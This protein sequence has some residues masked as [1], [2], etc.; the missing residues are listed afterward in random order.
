MGCG[1]NAGFAR[2]HRD[3]EPESPP[4][5][6]RRRCVR[7]GQGGFDDRAAAIDISRMYR[8]V[9]CLAFAAVTW[10]Q[11]VAFGCDMGAPSHQRVAVHETTTHHE[12]SGHHEN[13]PV[14]AH[15]GHNS[16]DACLMVLA[17][18]SASARQAQAAAIVR[19]PAV[20]VRVAF[21]AP[22]IPVA[23]DLAVETPPPRHTV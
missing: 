21:L 6:P 22:P 1:G 15:G 2:C 18:G 7:N 5:A 16:G 23:A 13:A 11:L 8:P 19:F 17:C 20:F 4:P 14:P 9:A 10:S 12:A 3:S